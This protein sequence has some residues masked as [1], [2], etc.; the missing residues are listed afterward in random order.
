MPARKRKLRVEDLFR[1]KIP[2]G[3]DLG[4]DGRI[5]YSL[6]TTD[7]KEN[8]YRAHLYLLPAG[9][10]KARPLT[11]GQTFDSLPTWSPD[12][13]HIAYVSKAPDGVPQIKVLSLEGGEPQELTQLKGGPIRHLSWSP[14]GRRILF[15]HRRQ[16]KEDPQARK[17]GPTFKHITRVFHK[18][19]GDGFFPPERWHLWT[20][21]FPGGR[22]R[23]LTR[24]DHDDGEPAWS[25]DGRRI[26]FLSNRIEE[27][28][29]H[30]ENEDIFIVPV[31]GGRLRQ[32]T[33]RFGPVSAPAWS[34]DGRSIYYVGHFG[35]D[36]EWLRH[37]LHLYRIPV[38]GGDPV[39]LTPSL[40]N[41]PG[42]WIASDTATGGLG[43][44][45]LHPYRD[46]N[47]TAPR[48]VGRGHRA[49]DGARSRRPP[50]QS[51][52]ER[53]AFTVNE[54]GACRLYSIAAEGGA[55]RTELGGPVDV[56]DAAVDARTGRAAVAA[57]RIMDCGDVYRLVLDGSHAEEP[58][59][60][61]TLN[62][63]LLRRLDLTEP[64]EVI[65]GGA[66]N[67]NSPV[68]GW[69]LKPPGFRAGKRYPLVLYIHGGPMAQYGYVL[70]HELHLLA[71]QG[72]VVVFTNPRGSSG[73]GLRFMNCIENRWGTH[74]YDDLMA[75]VDTMV[76]KP[77]VDGKRLGV[78]GGSYGGFMTTWI[79]GHTQRFKAAVTQRQAANML[80]QVGSSDFGFLRTYRRGSTPWE[81]PLK[82][83]K[84]SPNYYVDRMQTPV[85]IIH[86]E[87]DLRCPI[88]QGEEL[89]TF[90]KL[91]RK[92]VEMIRFE[93]ES[94][95][96][97]RG[98]KPQN[99]AERLRRIVD[100]FARYL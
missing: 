20:V 11:R 23:Q 92:P 65:F 14:D 84:D 25:P 58:R 13:R 100:W 36:G 55:M 21:T 91:Q 48:T 9:S 18:L 67:K 38:H 63:P 96:L 94:H 29:Y 53:I 43:A 40:D 97:S 79:I 80:I 37:P 19:D 2:T 69:I 71:A 46:P 99:R 35:G 62:A 64:E 73:Y 52:P 87:Q 85:L 89:F 98:G 68:H 42:N 70:F 45:R 12:G 76:R 74:D 47:R 41:W 50:R 34:L 15:C 83:L 32:V 27:A 26:A 93:G 31:R 16:P 60:L 30:P 86:S 3:V 10:G 44:L 82:H 57:A 33:R 77:Y 49:D 61:T 6:K 72:Y 95:G 4:P 81:T 5:V 88:A 51:V 1:L 59:R 24:G 7:D 17:K 54:H 39:D 90:L 56:I 75:V 66:R 8:G 28:D 22:V 78:A